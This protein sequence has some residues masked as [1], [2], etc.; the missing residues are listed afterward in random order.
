PA[1]PSLPGSPAAIEGGTRRRER[2]LPRKL[3]V[4]LNKGLDVGDERAHVEN[5][6]CDEAES[7]RRYRTHDPRHSGIRGYGRWLTSLLNR[8]SC[9]IF[10]SSPPLLYPS[11]D[12]APVTL[13]A[14]LVTVGSP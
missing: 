6:H 5:A 12:M 7:T 13:F 14:V 2:R 11:I 8:S 9:L 10:P 3:R 1:G 4:V